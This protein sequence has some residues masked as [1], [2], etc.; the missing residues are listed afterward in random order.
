MLP[1]L[2][3]FAAET[4][5]LLPLDKKQTTNHAS[6]KGHVTASEFTFICDWASSDAEGGRA[7]R[8]ICFVY[9]D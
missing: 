6:G 4:A 3:V 5:L 9:V 8:R 7:R 1:R 2:P